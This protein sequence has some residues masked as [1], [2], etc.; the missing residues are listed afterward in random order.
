MLRRRDQVLLL[1]PLAALVGLFL[2]WPLL[3]GFLLTFTN[4]GPFQPS[5]HFIGLSNYVSALSDATF[6]D[7]LGHMVVIAVVSVFGEITLGTVVA[8]ALRQP[9]RGRAWLRVLLLLPWLLSPTASGVMWRNVLYPPTGFLTFFAELLRLP[10]PGYA[11][12]LGTSFSTIIITE[13]W[14]KMPLAIFLMLPG[15]LTIPTAY[16]DQ[17][18]LDGLRLW[19]QIRH[20]VLPLRRRLLLTITFLLFAEALGLSES[21]F[22]LTGG[23]PGTRT[24]TPGIYSY[25]QA[26][27]S[28]NWSTG[29]ATG[30]FIVAAVLIAGVSYTI[31]AG[32]RDG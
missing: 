6:R 30:W 25:I 23:G 9:F 5:P 4:A 19:G 8:L 32:N 14:R 26:I 31:L 22:F 16:W 2:L 11:L 15:L 28:Q 12:G 13:I 1:T 10:P 17:A 20:V 24:M 27:V 3:N 21:G 7:S 29:S 18:R